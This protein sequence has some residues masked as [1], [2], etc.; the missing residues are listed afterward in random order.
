MKPTK[1]SKKDTREYRHISTLKNWVNNPRSVSKEGLTRLKK[2]IEKLGQYKPLLITD[3]GTVL[4]G[5]M[6]LRA[7]EELKVED[8]WVSVVE[9]ETEEEKIQYALSD[10]DRAGQYDGEQLANL[11]GSFPDIDYA[12]F[13]IDIDTP[14]IITDLINK[15]APENT[16]S[17]KEVDTDELSKDFN[18]KCPRCGFEFKKE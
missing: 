15:V 18:C 10:N 17:N 7:Y 9:A 6:R 5:N 2:Q 16:S 1:T 8:V 4:G 14:V 3:N 11:V 13:A 12:D